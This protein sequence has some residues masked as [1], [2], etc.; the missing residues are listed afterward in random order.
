MAYIPTRLSKCVAY[1][2][3]GG[4]EYLTEI[5]TLDNGREQRN[6]RW[7][8]PRHKYSAEYLNLSVEAQE[9]ILAAFHA[10]RGRLHAFRFK[11]WNDYA[12]KAEPLAPAIGTSNPVQLVKTYALGAQATTRPIQAPVSAVVRR[13]GVAVSGSLDLQTGLF[14]PAAPWVAGAYNWGGEFDVWVR[15]DSDYNAFAIGAPNART[16]DVTLIEVRR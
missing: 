15:F 9:E 8:Y 1:G 7:L 13:D 11:D 3:S 4:P 2:F 5:I 10:A 14:T 6:Q 16:A 12:A